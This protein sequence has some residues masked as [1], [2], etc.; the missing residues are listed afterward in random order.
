MSITTA[1]IRGARGLLGWNQS[2]LSDRTGISTTSIGAIENGNTQARESTLVLIRRAFEGGGVEFIGQDGVRLKTGDV[3][4]FVG[5]EGYLEFFEDVYNTLLAKPG[6]V[7]VSNVD[8][9][10]FVKW[11]GDSGDRHVEQSARLKEIGVSYKILIQEG[12]TFFPAS[13]FAEYRWIKKYLFSTVP[14]YVY[15]EKLGIILFDNEPTIISLNYPAIAQAY[16]KQFDVM[17][18]NAETISKIEQLK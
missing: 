1:Q 14:F 11:H 12:D 9:R 3:R 5:Q 17:W 13:D 15:G 7:C 6:T 18:S 8:E 2:D 4:I 10:K 16:Q